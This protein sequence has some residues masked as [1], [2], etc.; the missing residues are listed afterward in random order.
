MHWLSLSM[1]TPYKPAVGFMNIL[2][3]AIKSMRP[4]ITSYPNWKRWGFLI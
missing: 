4:P 2:N 1:A 3:L